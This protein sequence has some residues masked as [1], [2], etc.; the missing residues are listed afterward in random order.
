M[1]DSVTL[2]SLVEA[3]A[4]SVIEAQHRIENHHYKNIMWY[5]DK[6][7]RP[8]TVDIR[9]PNMNPDEEGEVEHRIPWLALVPHSSLKIKDVEI[10]FDVELGDLQAPKKSAEV[11]SETSN[12]SIEATDPDNLLPRVA[13]DVRSGILSRH[14]TKAHVKL[15]VEGGEAPDGTARLMHHLVKLV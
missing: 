8:K 9:L 10:E 13:V 3:L 15:R 5:F 1:S 12:P 4:G 7:H 11:K 14:S 6:D 2:N